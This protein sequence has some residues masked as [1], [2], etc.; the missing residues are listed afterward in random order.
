MSLESLEGLIMEVLVGVRTQASG[1]SCF[2]GTVKLNVVGRKKQACFEFELIDHHLPTQRWVVYKTADR[3]KRGKRL[4]F[5]LSGPVFASRLVKRLR[6]LLVRLCRLGLGRT[7]YQLE[8][9]TSASSLEEVS[10]TTIQTLGPRSARMV[11]QLIT[12]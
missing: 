11:S 9:R 1:L 5:A 12:W 7:I 4:F 3:R 8:Q 10:S 6:I 2:R